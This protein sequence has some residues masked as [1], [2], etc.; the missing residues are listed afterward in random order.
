MYFEKNNKWPS[1]VIANALFFM[2]HTYHEEVSR[3][4]MNSLDLYLWKTAH[5][6]L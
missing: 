3:A 6:F 1:C 4:E 5:S 2:E